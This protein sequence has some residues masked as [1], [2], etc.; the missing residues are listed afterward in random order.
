MEK[1]FAVECEMIARKK[2]ALKENS[3]ENNLAEEYED[4]VDEYEDLLEQAYFLTRI[5]DRLQRKLE[6]SNR[7]LKQTNEK[8]AETIDRLT[9]VKISRKARTVIMISAL[10]LFLLIEGLVEP[11]VD[12]NSR[13][14]YA[15]LAAKGV[16]A[17]SIKPLETLLER[18]MLKK[19][20][21]KINTA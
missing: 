5:G 20:R 12:A 9:E 18:I 21:M 6:N 15:S 19:E 17:L 11:L 8:L 14:F 1:I 7:E 3:G 13:N 10:A 4:L 16:I 2:A